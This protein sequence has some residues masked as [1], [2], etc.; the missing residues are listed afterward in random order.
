MNPRRNEPDAILGFVGEFNFLS[1]FFPSSVRYEGITFR[2]VEHAFQAAKTLDQNER[3]DIMWLDTP[4]KAKRAGHQLKLRADWEA[5]KYNVMKEL[6]RL[7]FQ[8]NSFRVRLLATH[9]R[10]LEETND[11][12][13]TCWGVCGGQGTN[14]LGQILMEV[15]ADLQEAESSKG[16]TP[17]VIL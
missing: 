5:V 13:D 16:R 11:W 2:S 15:R 8:H 14:W 1:N 9:D 12:H 7:K 3:Y 17:G 6:V 4:G 10:Y